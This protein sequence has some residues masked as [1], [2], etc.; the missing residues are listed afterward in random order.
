[1]SDDRSTSSPLFR[2]SAVDLVSKLSEV[3]TAE[4][5]SMAREARELASIFEAWLTKR[6]ENDARSS[7]IA[8][9]FDLHRR[10]MDYLAQRKSNPGAP[11]R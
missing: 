6:P 1:M 10:A 4:A 9:L 7:R 8:Q 2:D 3:Q 11:R 5:A